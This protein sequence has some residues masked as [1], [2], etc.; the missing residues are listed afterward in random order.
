M[1]SKTAETQKT[2]QKFVLKK[3]M[4]ITAAVALIVF[5]SVLVMAFIPFKALSADVFSDYDYVNIYDRD[6]GLM[7]SVKNEGASDAQKEH[8]ALL[9]AGLAGTKHS[10]LRSLAEFNFVNDLRYRTVNKETEELVYDDDD[11]IQRDEAG[12]DVTKTVKTVE[13]AEIEIRNEEDLKNKVREREQFGAGTYELEFFFRKQ[14]EARK[15]IVIR[16][17][18]TEAKENKA[19][20]KTVQ[21][22]RLRIVINDSMNVIAKYRLYIYDSNEVAEGEAAVTPVEIRMNTTKLYAKL[23]ELRELTGKGADNG[24]FISDTEDEL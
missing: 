11:F 13:R 18:S 8:T 7:L 16:D 9:K 22:D 12:L 20:K 6:G 23:C 3:W 24:E 14:S 19:R 15:E 4:I 10:L 17:N 1:E 2:K 5:V 21:F